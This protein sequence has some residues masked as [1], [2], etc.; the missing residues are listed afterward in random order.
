LFFFTGSEFLPPFN[1]GSITVNILSPAGTSLKESNRIGTIAEKLILEV[2]EVH[3]VG[4][5]TGRAEN[6]EHAEGVH[7][8]EIELELKESDRRREEVLT[9]LR[10]KLNTLPGI[11]VNIGQPISHRIDHLLS[12]IRAQ[13][14]VK[15]FGE[16]LRILRL[17]A[18]EIKEVMDT[19]PGVVDL[20]VEQQVLVPE[21]KIE[22]DR[23][24]A[25]QFGING[26]EVAELLESTLAGKVVGQLFKA[27]KRYDVIL[28]F[29]DK[30]RKDIESLKN[31][32]IT[33]PTGIVIPLKMIASIRASKSPNQILLPIL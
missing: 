29:P 27:Q 16:D 31:S 2:P 32:L 10:D 5:R 20:F 23:I 15:L 14:A 17:K 22:V 33:T 21:V 18:E 1:E 12:G 8:S 11:V 13:I 30:A 26:G 4:R 3:R 6:D 19:V 24:K 7:A 9:E 25:Q 28:R